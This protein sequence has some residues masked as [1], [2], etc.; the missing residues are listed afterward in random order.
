MDGIKVTN[1]KEYGSGN[2]QK[3]RIGVRVFLVQAGMDRNDASH[4]QGPKWPW[5]VRQNGSGFWSSYSS[6]GEA[7]HDDSW[8][9]LGRGQNAL[10]QRPLDCLL[11][12]TATLGA[13]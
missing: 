4:R 3:L 2:G 13:W 9:R 6:I 1:V 11:W 12:T 8:H 10:L 5:Y 7:L